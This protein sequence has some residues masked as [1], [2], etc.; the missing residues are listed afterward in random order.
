MA[1]LT[2]SDTLAKIPLKLTF[3]SSAVVRVQMGLDGR[4][5]DSALNRFGFIADTLDA[6]VAVETGGQGNERSYKT[7]DLSVVLS[8]SDGQIRVVRSDGRV[9][10]QQIDARH[11]QKRSK[12]TFSAESDEDWIG[13]G[14]RTRE[15]LFHRGHKADVHVRNVSSYVPVPFFMSTRGVGVLVNT[16]HRTVFDMC[17]SSPDQFDWEDKSG[18]VDYYIFAGVDF[19]DLLDKYTALTGR[20][21]LPPAWAFGLW[22]ICRTQANDYEAVNDALNFRRERIPCDVIGLEP[23]WMEQD[24]DLSIEKKW[25]SDRFPI[26][27]YAQNGPHNF[28]NA[29]KRMGF[30]M[31]LWLC[32][33]YDLLYEENRRIQKQKPDG[34]Q[35][36]ENVSGGWEVDEHLELNR[37]ADDI[38]RRDVPWFEH[39]KKFVDQGID[40]FK[41][42]GAFQVCEHPDR[43]WGNE[44]TDAEMHNLYPLLYSRQMH[45]GFAEHTGRRPV[46]FTPSGWTGFQAW[47]GTWTGDT[48][49]RLETLGGML[50]TALVGHSWLTN[51]M[52]VAQK[53]GIHF[54]YLQPWS[55]INSWNYFRMPWL[56]GSEL[57]ALHRF[58]GRL[59]SRLIP[60]IYSW[61]HYATM[62]GY[63]LMTPLPL[64]F[65][66][67]LNCRNIL[68][69]YLLGRD[70]L[71]TIYEKDVYFPAGKWKDVWTG[72][73]YEGEKHETICW[74]ANRGGGLFLR[75]GGI[76]PLGPVSQYHGEKKL[77]DVELW[78]FPDH[79]ESTFDLYEDDGETFK[80]QDGEYATTKVKSVLKND[81]V[82]VV[83][84]PPE[85]TFCGQCTTR[86]WRLRLALEQVPL[87]VLVNGEPLTSDDWKWD[88]AHSELITKRL[89]QSFELEV[90][91]Q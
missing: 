24:Y 26:P 84:E 49:G 90:L 16:T 1:V 55:Q 42:D 62:T 58:Y 57:S 91:L 11:V 72:R 5:S 56:Q 66:G 23:G 39:L 27:A 48:G 38:T 86:C 9:L 18:A 41:Q 4:I 33:E 61:A 35:K 6:D 65:P 88:R 29:I 51:D 70:L 12:V 67:D 54:G 34:Q 13:F 85:G 31:E 64:E 83:I 44:M 32:Q 28:I 74:P 63:P 17:C 45:E 78:I 80:F 8:E 30:H 60:Y 15:R 79:E 76:V 10:L 14:D 7:K 20:P 53:E 22:Y 19:K 43:L 21:K 3:L 25:N 68:H 46:V 50:N 52:E 37:C 73:I 81:R 87:E 2:F 75:N 36:P 47:C 40:F 77:S 69:E 71:V 89:P 82:S 59:R